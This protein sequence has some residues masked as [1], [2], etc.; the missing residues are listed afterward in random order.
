MFWSDLVLLWALITIGVSAEIGESGV[1]AVNTAEDVAP[2]GKA[3]RLL[4]ILCGGEECCCGD[5]GGI[6]A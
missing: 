5:L 2:G 3:G 6:C 4:S 1:V